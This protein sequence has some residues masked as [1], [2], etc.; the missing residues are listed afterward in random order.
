MALLVRQ[1]IRE[2]EKGVLEPENGNDEDMADKP[3]G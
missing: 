3:F 2:M 1:K